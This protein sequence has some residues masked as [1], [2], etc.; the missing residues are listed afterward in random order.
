M[1]KTFDAE[2][3][4]SALEN[5]GKVQLEY[6]VFENHYENKVVERPIFPFL[7]K[8]FKNVPK[9][10]LRKS[11]EKVAT[12]KDLVLKNEPVEKIRESGPAHLKEKAK[13][14][15]YDR[16][17]QLDQDVYGKDLILGFKPEVFGQGQEYSVMTKSGVVIG[18]FK[19]EQGYYSPN[20]EKAVL[21][22]LDG[23]YGHENLSLE[24]VVAKYCAQNPETIDFLPDELSQKFPELDGKIQDER[25]QLLQDELFDEN[26]NINES[27]E[28]AN[29][30]SL[31]REIGFLESSNHTSARELSF[32]EWQEVANENDLMGDEDWVKQKYQNEMNYRADMRANNDEHI[33]EA[34][35]ELKDLLKS[36]TPDER[37]KAMEF[38]N[39]RQRY[40]ENGIKNLDK[41]DNLTRI[42]MAW[43]KNAAHFAQR[44]VNNIEIKEQGNQNE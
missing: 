24:N 11:V 38:L 21:P 9:F 20:F 33:D 2:R 13:E 14:I 16:I 39:L 8:I 37:A 15:A 32:E 10:L 17:F 5:K 26:G 12:Y 27:H 43:Q 7:S 29:V 36:L 1:L 22:N 19:I 3:I 4:L 34:K 44:V 25:A 40:H 42:D 41:D 18:E 6:G 23:Q 35:D 31:I 30:E 28:F